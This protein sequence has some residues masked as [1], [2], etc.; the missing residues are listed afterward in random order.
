MTIESQE[1]IKN[2]YSPTHAVEIK[3]PDEQHAMVTYTA[4]NEVPT[5]DFRLFY[6]VGKGKVSTRVLSYRPDETGRGRLLPA[7]GQPGDQGR[8]TPSGRRRRW[9]SWSTARAA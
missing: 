7:P 1:E 9:S 3:R 8:R 4:K 2:V 5:T 6:D